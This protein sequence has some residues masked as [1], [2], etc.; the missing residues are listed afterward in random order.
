[1]D[2]KST[3]LAGCSLLFS[4]HRRLNAYLPASA[5]SL[6]EHNHAIDL[7]KQGVVFAE[8]DILPGVDLGSSLPNQNAT[9][10]YELA[11]ESFHP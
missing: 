9:G 5:G 2:E 7:G 10:S 6:L 1:L 11:A 4:G 8:T 3:L